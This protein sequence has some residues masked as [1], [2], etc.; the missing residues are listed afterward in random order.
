MLVVIGAVDL[1]RRWE[2]RAATGQLRQNEG[3][4][5]SVQTDDPV[6][7]LEAG[8]ASKPIVLRSRDGRCTLTATTAQLRVDMGPCGGR[9]LFAISSASGWVV[10]DHLPWLA[11]AAAADGEGRV[12]V[13]ESWLGARMLIAPP[14]IKTTSPYRGVLALPSATST[15]LAPGLAARFEVATLPLA[16]PDLDLR[17]TVERVVRRYGALAPEHAV[18]AGGLDSSSLVALAA[19]VTRVLPITLDLNGQSADRPYVES[20]SEYLGVERVLV[21]PRDGARDLAPDLTIHGAPM[22]WPTSAHVQAC[23][24]VAR[25]RGIRVVW[26]GLGGDEL[27]EGTPRGASVLA[28]EGRVR[29]AIE[30]AS[31]GAPASR[32]RAVLRNVIWAGL[33]SHVPFA[34]SYALSP[35][36]KLPVRRWAREKLRALDDE[37]ISRERMER[38]EWEISRDD[39]VARYFQWNLYDLFAFDRHLLEHG[40]GI[41]RLDPYTDPEIVRAVCS[42]PEYALIEGGVARAQLRKLVEGRMP[43]Q[44]RQ[45]TDKASF[46]EACCET[47]R[48]VPIE[49]WRS[50]ATPTA[51]ADLG[52][53]EPRVFRAEFDEFEEDLE[54]HPFGWIRLWPVLACEAFVRGVADLPGRFPGGAS[55]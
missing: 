13:E 10:S 40:G 18:L 36:A 4:L 31:R 28:H 39:K 27:F 17:D 38:P 32:T 1:L 8:D 35:R 44:V 55:A 24:R 16:A 30:L 49:H 29:D 37:R 50:L 52:L 5:A 7:E 25:E 53:V 12:A 51:L 54:G 26:S 23:V 11:S 6:Y 34:L 48:A 9:A 42:L 2:A 22:L 20:L 14:F 21:S 43:E 41:M 45:R 33:R 19:G 15:T 46:V 47:F 3:L